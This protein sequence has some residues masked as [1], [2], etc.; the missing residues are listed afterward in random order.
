MKAKKKFNPYLSFLKKNGLSERTNRNAFEYYIS[1]KE[2]P[3]KKQFLM[4][5]LKEGERIKSV[6]LKKKQF[7]QKQRNEEQMVGFPSNERSSPQ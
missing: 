5:R 6:R 4:L 7:F 3:L 1:K 2:H